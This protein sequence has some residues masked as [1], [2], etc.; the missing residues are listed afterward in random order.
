MLAEQSGR[1]Y[2]NYRTIAE[3]LLGG[4]PQV[5]QAEVEKRQRDRMEAQMAQVVQA[6]KMLMAMHTSAGQ[7]G[8]YDE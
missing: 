8:G 6:I 1:A 7:M 5:D 4:S 2:D 3:N